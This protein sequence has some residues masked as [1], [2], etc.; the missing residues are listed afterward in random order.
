M[1][2]QRRYIALGLLAL[3][4]V[5]ML[6]LAFRP[7]AIP[8]E[9]AT[10]V[11]G[12]MQVFVEEEARTRVIDRYVI[13]APV[14]GFLQ[15]IDLRAGDPAAIDSPLLVIEPMPSDVLDPRTRAAA[16]ARVAAAGAQLAAARENV[17]AARA[18]AELARSDA[19]RAERLLEREQI[20]VEEAERARAEALRTAAALRAAEHSVEVARYEL[21]AARTALAFSDAEAR[22]ETPGRVVVRSPV[23]GQ[24][25]RVHRESAGIVARGTPLLDVG[26]PRRL[27]VVAEVLSDQAVRINPGTRVLLERWGGGPPLEAAVR[28]VEPSGFTKISALGVEEQRVL[29]ISDILSPA[30]EWASL[31]DG[32]RVEAR[33]ILWEGDDVLQV[34]ASALFR[35]G[36]GW[37]AFVRDGDRARLRPVSVG[38]RNALRAEVRD[39][40]E[41]G[42]RVVIHP[43]D[44]L[45]DGARIEPA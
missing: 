22:G 25:L 13:S 45:S 42:D 36:E 37:A 14:A 26:N 44:A 2:G 9:E 5:V 32:Y 10:V 21:E 30:A 4:V 39:G 17:D 15:R 6:V 8:V 31:G 11:R 38:R 7:R 1:N 18:S 16:E 24:V 41:E 12:P 3:L 43:D 40:L 34:P 33:F 28:R 29:I 23:D 35:H 19:E 27:E 20:A